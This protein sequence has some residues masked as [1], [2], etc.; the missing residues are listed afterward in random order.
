MLARDAAVLD[1]L[2]NV[3]GPGTARLYEPLSKH[4]TMRV[5]G[6]AD[7]FAEVRNLFELRALVRFAR[8]RPRQG[9]CL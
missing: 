4:T 9:R 3:M 2:L 5:G 7:L 8:S 6:P 1:E